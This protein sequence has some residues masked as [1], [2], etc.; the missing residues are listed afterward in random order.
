MKSI[1]FIAV[2]IL[3][4]LIGVGCNGGNFGNNGENNISDKGYLSVANL[5]ID[6]R[7]DESANGEDG[8]LVPEYG[9][10]AMSRTSVDVDNFLCSI[11]N[12]EG[13]IVLEF[14][15]NERPTED[16]ELSTGEYILKIVSDELPATAWDTP[17]YGANQVFKIVRNDRENFNEVVCKLMQMMVSITYD[18]DLKKRLGAESSSFVK[19]GENELRYTL[20]ESRIGYFAAEKASNNIEVRIVGTYAADL[21][22]YKN[23]EMTKTV[24]N[25]KAGQ[26]RKIH[27]FL[28]HSADGNLDLGVGVRDWITDE[29]IP[30]N[31]ANSV[32]E[33]EWSDENSG[34]GSSTPETPAEDPNIV[35]DG[36]DISKREP[37]T[38]GLSVDLLVSASKGIKEF[39]V[40]IESASLT[41][42][43]LAGVGLCDVLNLCYPT[44]S[45][46]SNNPDT[47]IDVEEPLRGLGFAVGEEVVN[48]TFVK[49]SITQFMGVLQAVS[50]TDLKNHDF[51]LTV[52]DNK[53]NTCEKTLMLQTG[54]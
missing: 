37:I 7:L 6:T 14:K 21:V 53:G 38:G 48:K 27:L 31:V 2:A 1:K 28:E 12:E 24:Y 51:V 42:A 33:E 29:V 26:H 43:E 16:I 13:D 41:P 11:I 39:Y 19:I 49:L 25:V 54:K 32:G 5:V 52:V 4:A 23:V 10:S 50:G 46:D 45:Y 15:Y 40:K 3:A 9:K 18:P 22:N 36:H 20:D 34:G 30:C 17:V 8:G 47:Y 35:W 44:Q